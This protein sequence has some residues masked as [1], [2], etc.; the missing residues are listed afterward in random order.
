MKVVRLLLS[1][2]A[3]AWAFACRAADVLVPRMVTDS[4]AVVMAYGAE[5]TRIVCRMSKL[6]KGESYDYV[7]RVRCFNL[8]G[9]ALFPRIVG[10]LT[11]W[12]R[13]RALRQGRS[14]R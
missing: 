13:Y 5:H 7:A 9:L 1:V 8:F 4:V 14:S 11:P 12:S 2:C 3:G 10:D 6:R